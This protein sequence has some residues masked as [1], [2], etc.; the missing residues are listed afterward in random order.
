MIQDILQHSKK[1]RKLIGFNFYGTS[2]GF[3]CGYVLD[4]TDKFLIIQ[5]F[6]KI[7]VHDGILVKK[8]SDIKYFETET[9]YLK[10]INYLI[11]NQKE[12]L[13]QTYTYKKDKYEDNTF[14]K[15]FENFI[16][17]KEFIVKFEL[18]DEEIYYGFLEWCDENSF[19]IINIDNS[20]IVIGKA[21]FKF[22]D[23]KL[24]QIDEIECRKR[25]LL[26]KNNN[27]SKATTR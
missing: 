22:E 20:G 11:E 24:Y 3:Y 4:Y 10:G 19:S 15:I 14:T 6:T 27:Q 1:S 12:I 26:Y 18:N 25:V 21:I 16:G 7:G 13:T 2:A 17:N 5:H 9:D 23:I 8:I